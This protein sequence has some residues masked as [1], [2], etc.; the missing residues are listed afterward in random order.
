M[1]TRL[2]RLLAPLRRLLPA[3][4]HYP[5]LDLYADRQHHLHLVGSIHMGTRDMSPLPAALLNRLARADALV[6]EADITHGDSPFIEQPE[7]APLACRLS[8]DELAQLQHLSET[9]A[10]DPQRID[11][12]PGWQIALMF[13]AQQAQRLGLRPDYGIDYQLLRQAH[14]WRKPII[15]LEG[16]QSQLAMLQALPDNGLA[17]LQDTLTYWHSNARLLQ[18]M[19]GWWLSARPVRRQGHLPGSFSGALNDVLMVQRNHRWREQL[20]ALPAGRYVVAVGALHLFGEE[21]LPSLLREK[22]EPA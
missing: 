13:Q 4:W 15:E 14:A 8:S 7:D 1:A 2:E 16:P 5:A 19:I 18:T 21:N 12:L 6:V 22:K 10:I 3:P 20:L 9:L 17:L 11:R